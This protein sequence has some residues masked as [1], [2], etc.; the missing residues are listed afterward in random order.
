[1]LADPAHME[2]SASSPQVFAAGLKAWKTSVVLDVVDQSLE[3][4]RVAREE[5]KVREAKEEQLRLRDAARDQEARKNREEIEA[6][7]AR[8]LVELRQLEAD[9]ARRARLNQLA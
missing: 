8:R 4:A 3:A 1:M 9:S 5:A 6:E 7:D 2:L